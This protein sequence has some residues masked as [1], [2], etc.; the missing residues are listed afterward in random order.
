MEPPVAVAVSWEDKHTA[1]PSLVH[2][3]AS[4]VA[5]CA[6]RPSVVSNHTELGSSDGELGYLSAVAVSRA[7]IRLALSE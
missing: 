6:A 4:E 5:A 7:C 1:C 3:L 2:C